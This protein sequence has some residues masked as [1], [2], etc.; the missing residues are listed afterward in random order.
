MIVV[1]VFILI[2]NP[3]EISRVHNQKENRHYDQF[4][5]NLKEIRNMFFRVYRVRVNT[6]LFSSNLHTGN[7]F[8]K[9]G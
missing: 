3:T 5:F 1:T 4:S 8:L 2:I 6:K 9:P 7:S